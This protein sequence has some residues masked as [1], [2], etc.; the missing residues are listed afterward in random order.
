MI[1]EANERGFGAQ[2]AH[3]LL[4]PR[5]NDH[6]TVHAIDGFIADDLFG[7][8]AEADA[9]SQATPC[10]KYLFSV[11]LN[12]PP[13]AVV[14]VKVFER[15]IEATERKLGLTGQP[16]AIVF[17]EKNG[18]R[19]AHCV[20]SRIDAGRMKAI[21]LSH[22]KR[23]LTDLS[24]ELYQQHDWDMPDGF[25]DREKR[26][27]LNYSRAQAAQARRTKSDAKALKAMFRRC[28]DSSDS[29][30]GFAAALHEQGYIL[31]QGDRRGFVAV[32]AD[33]KVWSISRWCG[34]KPNDLRARLGPEDTL[35]TV[36][37]ARSQCAGLRPT[38]HSAPA[39]AAD[40]RRAEL[41]ARQRKERAK[42]LGAQ[43]ARRQRELIDRRNRLP[44]GLRA[45][46]ARLTGTLAK[47]LR[48]FE[49]E[50]VKAEQRDRV[51]QQAMVERHL[52]ER[53]VL[54]RDYSQYGPFQ[55]FGTA[56]GKETAQ[57]LVLPL[58]DL[59]FSR[60][61]L[62]Q[63]PALILDHI[64][65]TKAEFKR[66]DVMRALAERF[67]DPFALQN[68]TKAAMASSNLVQLSSDG[69][70]VF[71]TRDYQST[72][73]RL[74]R[75]AQKMSKARGFG[76]AASLIEAAIRAQN[77]RMQRAFSGALSDEQQR[78]IKHVLSGTQ[79]ASVVGLAGAGKSTMLATAMEAWT[80]Q[81]VKVHGAALAGKAADGLETA[82]GIKSRTL[83][84][85]ELAWENGYE[86]I[87]KGEVLVVDEA[88]MI[89]TRQ[90]ARITQK[91]D[92]IGAKL[93]LVG[94]P[95]QLQPIEAGTPFR[96]L[97]E[98]LGAARLTEIHRQREGWQKQASRDL[99][100]GQID[101]AV[102]AYSENSAVSSFGDRDQ[103]IEAI[104]ETYAMDAKANAS[105]SRLAFAHRR[106]DVH[107]L[108]QAIR[109]SLRDPESVQ[110]E[111]LLSTTTGPRAFA[112]RDRI[113]FSRNDRDLGVKNGMLGTVTS[114]R[115]G[116][117]TVD[118]D[119]DPPQKLTFDPGEYRDIDHGYAV[120][121]HK[122]QGATVDRAYVLASRSMDKHLAYVAMTR[123]RD[124][125]RLFVSQDDRPR[126]AQSNRSFRRT[127]DGPSRAGPSLG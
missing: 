76:V 37:K 45:A 107:A 100:A 67:E 91:M 79:L 75:I 95:D 113:V 23:K 38:E 29:L 4:N 81:G 120:T 88:G 85:L 114:V 14:P 121:I 118:L 98:T 82:S 77:R 127:R 123:H 110:P 101:K 44:K 22:Y 47:F 87:G 55:S 94:D 102:S 3:H 105:A 90:M 96:R 64:S 53:R 30:A 104:A 13:D 42:L 69:A 106:R 32:D 71:T 78:A 62:L 20:W 115:Q 12:P 25:R 103:T 65:R 57:S 119:G 56:P 11:S 58:D 66:T 15:A 51:E 116:K 72:E 40:L 48:A 89:G 8:F 36:E 59:P 41:V 83:A 21:T 126:W 7:A 92:E 5:D 28:W 111:A 26:D 46:W 86:P 19:H 99:A 68:A 73:A 33:G 43:E 35:P 24:R 108:N 97:V 61:Q 27:P 117:M 52:S 84:S 31:A 6:V 63:N 2:L 49:A 1:L 34:V 122:S 93:V 70:P 10:R 17:H 124:S 18:R 16:R 54:Q 39:P 80:K 50:T 74:D 60:A 109:A 9:I 125:L 112:A